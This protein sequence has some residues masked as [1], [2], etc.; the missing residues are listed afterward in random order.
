MPR[1]SFEI[2][3]RSAKRNGRLTVPDISPMEIVLLLLLV[4]LVFGAKR[5]PEISRSL[6]SGMREFRDSINGMTSFRKGSA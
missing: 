2:T 5:V 1:P 6:G 3:G 4:R